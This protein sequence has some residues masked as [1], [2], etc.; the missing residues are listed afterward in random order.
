MIQHGFTKSTIE[1]AVEDSGISFRERFM[2]VFVL[3]G[4][5]Y[6]STLIFS[7]GLY[8][9]IHAVLNKEYKKTPAQKPPKSVHVISNMMQFDESGKPLLYVASPFTT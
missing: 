1:K 8:D 4:S 9:V 7:A 5:K 6:V 3:L 2:P